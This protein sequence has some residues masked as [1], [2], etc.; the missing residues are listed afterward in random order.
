M[1]LT[2]L[3]LILLILLNGVFA[4]AELALIGSRRTRLQAEAA[5]GGKGAQAALKLLAN[6]GRFLSTVSIGITLIGVIVST[7]GGDSFVEPLRAAFSTIPWLADYAHTA[8]LVTVVATV[9]FCSVVFGELVPKRIAVSRP[10]RIATLL[11]RFMTVIST[12]VKPAEWVLSGTTQLVLG[13]LPIPKAPREGVSDEEINLMMREGAASGEFQPGE[14][15]IVQMTLRLGDR[16]VDSIMTP[17]TQVDWLDL[18]DGWETNREKILTS[19]LSRFPV[20][21]GGPR[22]VVGIVQV[23]DLLAQALSGEPFDLRKAT[24]PP[25]YIPDT[26]PALRL[27]ETLKRSGAP[28]A[29]VVDEYGEFEGVV[30]LHD[31]LQALVGDIAEP[32]EAED[33][34][35]VRRE[36]GSWLIDGL[37]PIEQVKDAIGV[38]H[39]PGEDSGEFHTLGGFLMAQIQ[40]VPNVADHVEIDG[41]RFEVVDMDG[42]RVDRVLVARTGAAPSA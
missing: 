12:I 4:M 9:T 2:I 17:R 42:H 7:E 11:S 34:A 21:E 18:E 10:E 3:I 14:S 16:H 40:R 33:Q 26:V 8:A 19:H 29:L 20:V 36:D 6:S 1:L 41:W 39:L 15:A 38:S 27:L 37:V 25:L 30:T 32:G 13:M 35:V 24:R 28:L 5:E 31:I 23:K 22:N